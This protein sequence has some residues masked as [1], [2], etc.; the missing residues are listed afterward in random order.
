MEVIAVANRSRESAAAVAKEFGIP[1]ASKP[2][3]HATP[4][5]ESPGK[6]CYAY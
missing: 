3:S 5:N 6:L 4:H 1:K 2:E